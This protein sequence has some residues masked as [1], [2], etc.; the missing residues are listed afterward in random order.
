MGTGI[1]WPTFC[2]SGKVKQIKTAI[3]IKCFI[4]EIHIPIEHLY[5]R[6]TIMTYHKSSTKGRKIEVNQN[7]LSWDIWYWCWLL[8]SIRTNKFDLADSCTSLVFLTGH[9]D[10]TMKQGEDSTGLSWLKIE[11]AHWEKKWSQKIICVSKKEATKMCQL[12]T[13]LYTHTVEEVIE[14]S[15]RHERGP[16]IFLNIYFFSLVWH[17][18][19]PF[20]V[21]FQGQTV[22]KNLYLSG[23]PKGVK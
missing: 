8:W 18:F 13:S 7:S 21:T 16:N 9:K 22:K 10:V 14:I 6:W 4:D 3:Q 23:Y 1:G 11:S 20:W 12:G 19:D 15:K 17:S 5:I 2:R